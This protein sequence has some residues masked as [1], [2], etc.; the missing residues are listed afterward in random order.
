MK[1]TVQM[2]VFAMAI[3]ASAASAVAGCGGWGGWGLYSNYSGYTREYIPY[4]AQNPPVYYSYP[5]PRPY[6]W[7]PYAYPPGTMTPEM[8][9]EAAPTP[10]TIQNPYFKP[11]VKS[12]GTASIPSSASPT[13][14]LRIKNPYVK[15]SG[16]TAKLAKVR[17]A[18]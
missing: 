6:G 12:E 4:F 7:S 10:V 13:V 1:R 2:L 14:A 3:G 15:Q 17:S 8:Q 18:K 9:F 16:A 11:E 5:V